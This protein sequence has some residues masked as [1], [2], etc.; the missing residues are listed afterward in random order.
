M[1][2]PAA[3]RIVVCRLGLFVWPGIELEEASW[4]RAMLY[5]SELI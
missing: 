2:K 3:G 4:H 5:I 1:V